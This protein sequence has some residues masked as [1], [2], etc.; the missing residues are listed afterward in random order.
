MPLRLLF[1]CLRLTH[2][3]PRLPDRVN[4]HTNATSDGRM[5]SHNTVVPQNTQLKGSF[6]RLCR[7]IGTSPR[8]VLVDNFLTEGDRHYGWVAEPRPGRKNRPQDEV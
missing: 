4:Q 1:V 5:R 7:A 6:G 3:M 2:L 8:E